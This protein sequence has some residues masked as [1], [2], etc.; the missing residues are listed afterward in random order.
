VHVTGVP[1]WDEVDI[2]NALL[3]WFR[4]NADAIRRT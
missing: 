4:S 2:R 1:G 3:F